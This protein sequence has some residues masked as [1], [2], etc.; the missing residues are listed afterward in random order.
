MAE[1]DA[2]PALCGAPA[3]TTRA[4]EG[5][6]ESVDLRDVVCRSGDRQLQLQE[7]RYRTLLRESAPAEIDFI[8]SKSCL[9]K[10]FMGSR[11][12]T[13]RFA[14]YIFLKTLERFEQIFDVLVFQLIRGM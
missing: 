13:P 9:R 1:R 4:D 5:D 3:N 7:R 6:G 2:V 10:R 14:I 12:P 11:K 8:T